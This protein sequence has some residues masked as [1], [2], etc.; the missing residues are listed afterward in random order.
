MDIKHRRSIDPEHKSGVDKQ[1]D[2]PA[3][4]EISKLIESAELPTLFGVARRVLDE[5]NSRIG[6]SSLDFDEIA[7]ALCYSRRTL[8]RRLD[9]QG[10]CF[11]E[12]RDDVRRYHGIHM[13]IDKNSKVDDIYTALDFSD[14]SSLNLAFKR[15]T[16]SSPRGFIQRYRAEKRTADTSAN[17]PSK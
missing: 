11:S 10:V 12:L 5:L 2:A 14:R 15:W 7:A 13:L 1:N 17:P 9:S 16:G 3:D 4:M 8:Q 6:H